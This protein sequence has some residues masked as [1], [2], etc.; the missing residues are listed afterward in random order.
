MINWDH[1]TQSLLGTLVHSL[2]QSGLLFLLYRLAVAL[3]QWHNPD[4]RR[5]GLLFLLGI[6]CLISLTSFYLL[7][8]GASFYPVDRNF[9]GILNTFTQDQSLLVLYNLAAIAYLLVLSGKL[10]YM[11]I[12]D[13]TDSG[14]GSAKTIKTSC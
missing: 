7:Y 9:T 11:M 12:G 5:N 10:A 14:N 2:W 13:G 3:F 1:F 6:Q 4:A 8:Q